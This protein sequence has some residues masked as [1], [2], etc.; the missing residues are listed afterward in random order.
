MMPVNGCCLP[1]LIWIH[2]FIGW[3]WLAVR[4]GKCT[5]NNSMPN[6]FTYL[7]RL[8]KLLIFLICCLKFG[9]QN[10]WIKIMT[11]KPDSLQI[12]QQQ[13][14][15]KVIFTDFS[16]HL[17]YI[18]TDGVLCSLIPQWNCFESRWTPDCCVEV[19]LWPQ[20]SILLLCLLISRDA[21]PVE[22]GRW[23]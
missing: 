23:Y 8:F 11:Q 4:F 18:K 1:C 9:K 6:Y 16:S 22:T 20:L 10:R 7:P 3:S 19:C 2:R 14:D 17:G 15:N 21:V 5:Q 12:K 13:R